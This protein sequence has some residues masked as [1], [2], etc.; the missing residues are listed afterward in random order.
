MKLALV[1]LAIAAIAIVLRL[2]RRSDDEWLP[3]VDPPEDERGEGW[4][5]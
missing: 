1:L 5:S 3:N 2:A 4:S